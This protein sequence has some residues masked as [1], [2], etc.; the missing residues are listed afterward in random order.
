MGQR[1]NGVKFVE[2]SFW[3]DMVCFSHMSH[4]VTFL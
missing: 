3:N 1:M 2:D 4:D